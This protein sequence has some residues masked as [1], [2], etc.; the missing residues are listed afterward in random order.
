[1]I[2]FIFAF[3]LCVSIIESMLN[4]RVLYKSCSWSFIYIKW[5]VSKNVNS[6]ANEKHHW[7]NSAF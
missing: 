2:S 3:L 6:D 5:K 1:M 7:L 4:T